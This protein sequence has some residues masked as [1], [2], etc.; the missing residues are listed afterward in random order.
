M[1]NTPHA[2]YDSA[3]MLRRNLTHALRYPGLS[4]GT[5]AVPVIFLLLFV[6]VLGGA[7][8]AGIG[9]G[10]HYIDYLAPGI[11][12]MTVSAASMTTAV[13]VCMDLTEG[14]VARFRTMPISRASVLVGHVLGSLILTMISVGLVIG[15]A[16]LIG[17]RPTADLVHW[18]AALGVIVLLT[19]AVTWMAVAIGTLSRSPEGASNLVLPLALLPLIGSTFVPAQSMSPGVRI[20]AQYQPFTPIIETIRGLLMGT[21]IGNN[22]IV[23]IAWCLGI[24]VFAYFWATRLFNRRA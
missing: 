19:L 18:L 10:A 11:I 3:T 2:L 12:L 7:L 5:V 17:F 1:I 9:R 8:G 6:Y 20:V 16:L 23:A 14:V 21:P 13:S 22:A 15:I 4:I 24:T